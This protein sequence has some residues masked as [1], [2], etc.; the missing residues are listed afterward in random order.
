MNTKIRRS[1]VKMS[2]IAL[3]IFYAQ[4]VLL[5]VSTASP[6]SA[7]KSIEDIYLSLNVKGKDLPATFRL[8]SEKTNFRFIY[9]ENLVNGKHVS[10]KVRKESLGNVL[11]KISQKLE[12]EFKRINNDILVKS[13]PAVEVV[14]QE[15]YNV[16]GVVTDDEGEPLPGATVQEKGTS[17]GTITDGEG[18]FSLT[19]SDENSVLVISYIGYHAVE[20]TANSASPLKIVLIYDLQSLEEV[21]VVGYGVEKKSNLTGSVSTV[22]SDDLTQV[23]TA[24]TSNLISGR[25]PGVVAKQGSG[26]P[27]SDNSN[28]SI[29][30]F[31]QPLVLVDGIEIEDGLSRTDPNDIETIS[32][33]KDAAAA[34]YGARAAN[35][36]ILVTTK[37]G[38]KEKSTITYDGSWTF[39]TATAF[40]KRVNAAEFVEL[41]READFNEVGDFDTQFSADD[42]EKYRNGDPGYEGGDWVDALI[43]NF[44]PMQQHS[45]KIS[46]GSESVRYFA[47]V[48]TTDQESFFTARD[49]DYERRNVRTNLDIDLNQNLSFNLDLAY[50]RD[51]RDY[52][53][54][55]LSEIFNDLTTAAPIHPTSLPDPSVGVAFSGFSQRNPVA[56]TD[57]DLMGFDT[58]IDNTLTGKLGLRYQ[59]PGIEGLSIRTELNVVQLNRSRKIS[60]FNYQVFQFDPGTGEYIDQGSRFASTAISDEEFRR[61]QVYPLLALDYEKSVGDHDFKFLVLGEQIRRTASF[62]RASRTN[63]LSTDVPEIFNASQDMDATD[64]RSSADIGRKSFVSRFNYRYKDKLLVEATLRADGNVLFSPEKRW[65][66][67]PSVSLG[68][69]LSEEGFLQN[70]NLID[71][72]KLRLSYTQ[73]GDDRANGINGFDYLAGYTANNIPGY[74]LGGA[75]TPGIRTLG[76]ANPLL[77]WEVANTY[78]FGVEAEFLDGKLSFEADYFYR[79]RNGILVRNSQGAPSTFG[80]ELP[81]ENLNSLSNRGIELKLTYQQVFGDFRLVVSPNV[82]FVRAKWEDVF[83]QEV[84]TDPDQQRISG[85]EGQWIN[86]FFGYVSDGIFMSQEEIESHPVA[87]DEA[88]AT[89]RNSTIRPGDIRYLDLDGNDTIN[90]RDQRVIAFDSR[91]PELLY[92]LNISATY[93]NFSLGVL[94]QGASRFS[95]DINGSARTMFSNSSVPF[96]Y[97]YKYRWQPDPNNPGVN[98]NPN[99]QLPAAGTTVSPNNERSSDFWRRDVTYLRLKNI[100]LAYN[101]PT[102]VTSKIGMDRIQV[103][104]AAENL[105]TLSNLGIYKNAFDPEATS[106][107]GGPD[108]QRTYP[109]HRNYTFGVRATF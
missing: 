40:Q 65:G 106:R 36:V 78:N 80:A 93:K 10:L 94:F 104:L 98:I 55:G 88:S 24:N 108:T 22:S 53:T 5:S 52:P 99:A 17:N 109:L 35:G 12:L 97:H 81:L 46:G 11:R 86:R 82:T 73:L 72:L 50:R 85:R 76:L 68:W 9:D 34:V 96:D 79:K 62:I 60:Q 101:I 33:L 45:L 13:K 29:R 42:L 64:G 7:Q 92:G 74:L 69:V 19:V 103:Y 49:H 16:T 56:R 54:G 30:G 67:F 84:F 100:N 4:T 20:V 21:V 32:V 27:G 41:V 25:L 95:I 18:K 31:G 51:K 102:T 58:R 83:D 77:S 59:I 1:I 23:P 3:I 75:L 15:A 8:I 38:S 44:A 14:V 28:L 6:S 70:S 66:Y 2:R 61:S 71:F 57:R 87:Q 48:G 90:F 39:Q 37:R 63:L 47:S 91:L 43:D 105:F 89:E 26:L 107:P